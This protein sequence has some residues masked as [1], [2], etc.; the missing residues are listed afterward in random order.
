MLSSDNP[1]LM[2]QGSSDSYHI[3]LLF[4]EAYMKMLSLT[5]VRHILSHLM[6]MYVGMKVIMTKCVQIKLPL[7]KVKV[8]FKNCDVF[9]STYSC[10]KFYIYHIA[11]CL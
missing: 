3:T 8:N 9:T 4:Q 6:Y 2:L 1:D 11:I 5:C 10:L 7:F